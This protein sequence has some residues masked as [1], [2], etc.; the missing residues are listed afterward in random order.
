MV[1]FE[2]KPFHPNLIARN[3]TRSGTYEMA[4]F[5]PIRGRYL[6]KFDKEVLNFIFI[7][8]NSTVVQIQSLNM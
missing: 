3:G 4:A 7:F 6:E 1:R 5:Q 2:P 8:T